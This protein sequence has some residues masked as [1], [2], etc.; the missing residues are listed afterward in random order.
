M[1]QIKIVDNRQIVKAEIKKK[2]VKGLEQCGLVAE[3]Y[4]KLLAPVDTG[5]LRNSISHKVDDMECYI[6]TNM[7]YAPY[8]EYG[9]GVYYQGGRQTPWV[10]KASDGNFYMTKGQRAQPFLKPSVANHINQYKSILE[11]ALK[12]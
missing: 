11:D 12:E 2:I 8:V 5:A 3:G 7:E 4:A 1:A 10:Y 9:T 6:G